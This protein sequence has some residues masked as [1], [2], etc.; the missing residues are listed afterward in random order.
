M[1]E[2]CTNGKHSY[3]FLSV[4]Q[5]NKCDL[6]IVFTSFVRIGSI[7]NMIQIQVNFF[8]SLYFEATTL[9]TL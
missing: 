5:F 1:R 6:N 8:R 7:S 9:C 2:L 4:Q 3:I